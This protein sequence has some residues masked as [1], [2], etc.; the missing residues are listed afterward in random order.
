M[1]EDG[2]SA[3]AD[4]A[5]ALSL[6]EEGRVE[7]IVASHFHGFGEYVQHE[8]RSFIT[9]GLGAPLDASPGKPAPF[10]H[11]LLVGVPADGPLVVEVVR[12]PD[13]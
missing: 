9:G 10:H 13:R 7:L 11:F 5:A 1:D 2:P 8:I 6:F 4:S 3:A 12:F